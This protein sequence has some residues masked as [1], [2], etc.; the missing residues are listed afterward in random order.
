MPTG[1]F[2]ASVQYGDWKGVASADDADVM[3]KANA[4]SWLKA[5]KK[6]QEDELLV[7]VE[8]WAGENHGKHE[9]PVSVT[10]LIASPRNFDKVQKQAQSGPLKVRRVQVQMNVVEFFGLFKRFSIALSHHG[11]LHEAEYT[12]DE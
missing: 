5:R 12:Y 3:H 2:R 11:I 4:E 7:A 6:I 1:R 10:F 8:L 9:D